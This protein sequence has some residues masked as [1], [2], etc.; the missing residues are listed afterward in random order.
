MK[1]LLM[2][3]AGAALAAALSGCAAD[4]APA[5][6]TDVYPASAGGDEQPLRKITVEEAKSA[7]L[8]HAGLTA[9]EVTFTET[10][11]DRDGG[12]DEYEIE[13]VTDTVKYEY[14]IKALDG[15]VL[16]FS[17]ERIGSPSSSVA[18]VGNISLEEAKS[19]AL[20]HAGLT[21]GEVTF[22]ET[23]L[24][25][26][27]GVDEYDIEF[28]TDTTKYEYE[29][30]ALD[31]AVLKFSTERIGSSSS[32]VAV[33]NI[34]L[35][36]AKSAALKHAGLTAGEVTFTETKLDRDD[37]VDEYDIEFV[38]DAIKYEY[39]I[40]AA[41]GSVLKFSTERIGSS[42]SS[43]V[44]AVGNISLE[45]AKSAALKHAGLTAGEVTFTE[46]KLDRDG[47]VDEYD[48]EFVTDA[49]KY[50]YEIR[51]LDGAVLKF[52]TERIGSSAS[53]SAAAV[54]NISLEEAKSAA[55]KH[56][57]L[58]AGEVTFTE[59]K[60]DR[61]GGVDE[62]DIEF[63]TDAIKYE[64]EIRAA[65]GVVLDCS[66][67]TVRRPAQQGG[68]AR[69]TEAEAKDIAARHAGFTA[70]GVTF[71]KVELDYDDGRAEY[72]IEFRANGLEYELTIDA[73]SGA[74][75]EMEVDD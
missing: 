4:G 64:Y 53:Q 50:E 33:G 1:K 11:L 65:D 68:S 6:K 46:T 34:S 22:T 20:K 31:G 37:G 16:K 41:D 60:L 40:R 8:K 58:T 3:A 66:A 54:G 36:E 12:V 67:E 70:G 15:A 30:K 28:V 73:D 19:A 24:D 45:D 38:T 32:S 10:K 25:R 9:G 62:Y 57:G 39:E 75:L 59:T 7:A 74:V 23:K 44:A 17:T 18:A 51:A 63:V 27:G 29:I 69:I 21:A 47:G 56:A 14:E 48:I 49:I 13:F 35:E 55:L 71:V 5:S 2:I 43:G 42:V 52:S 72:E 26:D 61:D